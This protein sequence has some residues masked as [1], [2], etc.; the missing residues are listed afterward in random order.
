MADAHGLGARVV[1]LVPPL[2]RDTPE[3]RRLWMGQTIS[4]VGDQVTLIA[5]PLVAVLALG[6]QPAEMGYL[7]AAG[8]L[9]HLLFSLVA[10]VAL[11][12][13]R[14]RRR[15]MIWADIGRAALIATIPL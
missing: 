3:F 8:L 11:D 14:S 5:L 4:V 13:V 2:L 7:T 9:P 10:G 6:A 12:R 15:L 1:A